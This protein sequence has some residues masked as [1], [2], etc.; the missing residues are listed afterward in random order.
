MSLISS[1]L[2]HHQSC[3]P[4]QPTVVPALD[5]DPDRDAARL[6]TAIK[7]KGKIPAERTPFG[8]AKNPESRT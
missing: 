8:P 6:E 1:V 3:E 7:T 4:T 2:L 5:F